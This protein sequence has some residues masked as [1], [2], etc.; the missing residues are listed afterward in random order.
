MSGNKGLDKKTVVRFVMWWLLSISEISCSRKIFVSMGKSHHTLLCGPLSTLLFKYVSRRGVGYKAT[1]V[2]LLAPL[3]TSLSL[4]G[5]ACLFFQ[6]KT[7]FSHCSRLQVIL[8]TPVVIW[9]FKSLL[10]ATPTFT[11]TK[12]RKNMPWGIIYNTQILSLSQG[13]GPEW[14]TAWFLFRDHCDLVSWV[15]VSPPD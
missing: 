2:Q 3:C 8:S 14:V 15:P 13:E 9:G 7:S 12:P 6:L 10:M 4:Q 1:T 5:Q 11:S